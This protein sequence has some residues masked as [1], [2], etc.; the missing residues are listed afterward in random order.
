MFSL[1]GI[2]DLAYNY[3]KTTVW[4]LGGG[5]EKV[6]LKKIRNDE[7]ACLM[8]WV[9]IRMQ[10]LGNAPGYLWNNRRRAALGCVLQGDVGSCEVDRHHLCVV[11]GHLQPFIELIVPDSL[12]LFQQENAPCYPVSISYM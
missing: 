4:A 11:A 8:E 6:S 3:F 5:Q 9:G 12:G 10:G 2:F 7:K 1:A